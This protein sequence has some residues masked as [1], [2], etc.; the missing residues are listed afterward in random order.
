[1]YD[2][3]CCIRCR[4]HL[5]Y[6]A[7]V[8]YPSLTLMAALPLLY[9]CVTHYTRVIPFLLTTA[10]RAVVV[11]RPSAYRGYRLLA[12]ATFFFATTDV[13]YLLHP[14][15]CC[16]IYLATGVRAGTR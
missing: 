2:P 15:T 1:M 4:A 11:Y 10:Q 14:Y 8:A 6:V 9:C 13:Y 7:F 16:G 12:N 3:C 5:P